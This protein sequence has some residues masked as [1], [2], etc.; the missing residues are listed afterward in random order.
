MKIAHISDL[1]IGR[2]LED[3]NLLEDQNYVLN[4]FIDSIINEDPDVLL[5]AGDVYDKLSPSTESFDVWDRFLTRLATLRAHVIIISGNHDSKDRLGVGGRL[6][7]SHKIHMV[8]SIEAYKPIEIED[9]HGSVIFYPI[10]FIKPVDVRNH[11]QD[12]KGSSYQEAY[13]YFLESLNID[14]SKR[15]V[16]IGHQFFM[17]SSKDLILS[18]SETAKVGGLDS[19]STALIEDF[20]YC[21]LG[22]IHGPQMVG[23][24]TIRYSGSPLKYSFSE[25]NHTKSYVLIDLTEKGQFDFKLIPLESKRDLREIKGPMQELINASQGSQDYIKAIITDE[26]DIFDGMSKLRQAYPNIVSME[27]HN[28]STQ[29]NAVL[30]HAEDLMSKSHLDRFA[31]LYHLQHNQEMTLE[32]REIM[33]SVFQE[34]EHEAN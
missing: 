7:A 8:T 32:E 19:I 11:F 24:E 5:I 15:N 23:K 20:D 1:H 13:Q 28:K 26:E 33:E 3:I 18:D 14:Y 31:D 10:P 21:A 29:E 17:N 2:K 22:H 27:I 4:C 16:L 9:E 30:V 34:V 6:Y 12:Y 25:K